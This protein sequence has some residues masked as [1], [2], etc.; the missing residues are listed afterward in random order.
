M[1]PDSEEVEVTHGYPTKVWRQSN[2]SE[3]EAVE[4]YWISDSRDATRL[5]QFGSRRGLISDAL[6][7]LDLEE[8]IS[9]AIDAIKKACENLGAVSEL[10]ALMQSAGSQLRAF[11]LAGAKPYGR[12]HCLDRARCAQAIAASTGICW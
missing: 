5:L 10:Q 12:R 1:G 8:S 11:I 2:R 4:L 9:A 3:R 6:A 7:K